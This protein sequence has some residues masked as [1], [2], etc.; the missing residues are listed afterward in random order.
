MGLM[1]RSHFQGVFLLKL[2]QTEITVG[3]RNVN[4]LTLGSLIGSETITRRQPIGEIDGGFQL[5]TVTRGY[6][7][8][9]AHPARANRGDLQGRSRGDSKNLEAPSAIGHV[10]VVA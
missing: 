10:G 5:V 8:G 4:T 6:V 9:D 2:L 3:V 1:M 7:H